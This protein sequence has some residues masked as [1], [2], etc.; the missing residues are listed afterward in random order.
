[1]RERLEDD[2][3]VGFF[4]A[5]VEPSAFLPGAKGMYASTNRSCRMKNL[6]VPDG[7]AKAPKFDS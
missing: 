2:D 3:S 4:A 6:T 1:M 5:L 7:G